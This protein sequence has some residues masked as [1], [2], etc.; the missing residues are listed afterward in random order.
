MNLL[1][2]LNLISNLEEEI[3]EQLSS[4]DILLLKN[5]NIVEFDDYYRPYFYDSFKDFFDINFSCDDIK[6]K[7][8]FDKL[9]N[10]EIIETN[11]IIEDDIITYMN[12]DSKFTDIAGFIKLK[13]VVY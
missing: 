12:N 7:E 1:N 6:N 13:D 8:I 10:G 9:Y 3:S 11:V 5:G 2:R 4:N